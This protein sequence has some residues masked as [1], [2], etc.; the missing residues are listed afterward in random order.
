MRTQCFLG[1]LFVVFNLHQSCTAQTIINAYAN[2]SGISGKSLTVDNVEET[3]DTFEIGDYVVVMQMQDEVVG[4][5]SNT[6][7]FGELGSI[8]SAGLYETFRISAITE[9]GGI[10]T[11][12]TLNSDP[13]ITFN[14]GTHSAVQVF[15]FPELG[16][17]NYTTTSDMAA[18]AWNGT[19][20][21]VLAFQVSGTLTLA[22]NL[23]A[24]ESGFRGADDDINTSCGGG[25]CEDNLWKSTWTSR[26]KKG[27][28]LYRNSIS[29]IEAGKG[30]LIN[31]GGGGNCHNGGGGGGSNFSAGGTGGIGWGCQSTPTRSAGGEGGIDL[32]AHISED[33][34]FM[35]G[36]GGAGERNNG[37][38]TGGGNG[39]GIILLKANEVSTSGSCGSLTISTNG[40]STPDIGNDGA[41]GAGGGGSIVV[42]TT[43]WNIASG[44]SVNITSNGGSGGSSLSSGV[45][46]GG[47]GGGQGTAIFS[48]AE[49]TINT[50]VITA[51]GVGGCGNSTSPCNALAD[52][53]GGTT[54]EGII[55]NVSGPLPVELLNFYVEPIDGIVQCNWTTLSEINNDYFLIEKSRDGRAWSHIEKV[56]GHGNSSQ[57]INYQSFDRSPWSGNSY[58]RLTQV[59]YDGTTTVYDPLSI[60]IDPFGNVKIFP[61]PTDSELTIS[62][63]ENEHFQIELLSSQGQIVE[64]PYESNGFSFQFDL[65]KLAKGVYFIKLFNQNESKVQRVV[66]N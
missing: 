66:L 16:S 30:K 15:S 20:G 33:R 5:T 34:V 21:G 28:G 2:V 29:T 47:G 22:H 24:N 10:P 36:G 62:F 51:P 23:S 54:D 27:E 26:A 3:Y 57:S 39:G 31:A 49:P 6:S 4:D 35:G 46:G 9:S 43:L 38:P 11:N 37:H 1:L 13:A 60:Y 52:D 40:E 42:E 64:I 48:I 53:G 63:K 32:S 61:N 59:D 14:T 17:P 44:C 18:L 8:R 50:S 56:A 7:A 58:Y 45:H 19:I 25:V 41:G 65:S 55:E 12:I